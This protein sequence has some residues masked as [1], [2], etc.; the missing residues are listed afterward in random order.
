MEVKREQENIYLF[1]PNIIGY[2]RIVLAI[3]SFYYMP[4][5]YVIASWCYIIS[6]LLD[7]LDG[8]AARHF[9]QSTKFGAMLDQL[10]DR[11]GTCGL[12]VTLSYFYPKYMFW[13]QLSM[14]IDV[15]CHWFYLH[16]EKRPTSSST[17]PAIQLCASTT[18]TA[19]C[20]AS[21]V[22]STSCSTPRCTCCTS[23]RVRCCSASLRSSCWQS[24][25]SRWRS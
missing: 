21:C 18:P 19:P 3:V 4:T 12:L 8:H 1:V 23:P 24:C 6:V 14:A 20:L 15:A 25:P 2:A 5:D 10:T 9:N 11:C 16:T 22:C 13:F 7:A 17:C